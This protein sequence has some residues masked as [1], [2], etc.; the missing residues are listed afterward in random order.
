M[1]AQG[2][3]TALADLYSQI[4]RALPRHVRERLTETLGCVD[5]EGGFTIER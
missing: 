5:G 1:E 2:S 3:D 4:D